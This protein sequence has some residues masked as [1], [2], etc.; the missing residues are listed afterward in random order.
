MTR[1][2]QVLSDWRKRAASLGGAAA[3]IPDPDRFMRMQGW[4]RASPW[5]RTTLSDDEQVCE[6][7]SPVRSGLSRQ[8]F[9]RV[10]QA[11]EQQPVGYPSSV[12]VECED[13]E[14]ITEN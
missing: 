10:E 4:G 2:E 5:L 8:W 7:E 14:R 13:H 6:P 9:Q 11:S 1:S 3:Q 12:A